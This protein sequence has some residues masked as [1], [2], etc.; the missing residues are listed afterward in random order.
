MYFY[1]FLLHLIWIF[2]LTFLH[3][4]HVST[5]TVSSTR[6]GL[7]NHQP[8]NLIDGHFCIFSCVIIRPSFIFSFCNEKLVLLG[9][10]LSNR[11]ALVCFESYWVQIAVSLDHLHQTCTLAIFLRI[12]APFFGS[13]T[14]VLSHVSVISVTVISMAGGKFPHLFPHLYTGISRH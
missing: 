13:P 5:M 1:T 8:I 4:V 12:I 11:Q 10:R 2:T 3:D 6:H 9:S 7:L 14:L